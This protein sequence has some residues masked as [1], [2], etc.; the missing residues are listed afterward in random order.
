MAE[1]KT[2]LFFCSWAEV[3]SDF[4]PADRC[5]VYD[6][7]IAYVEDGT[8]PDLSPVLMMAF[9]FIKKDIDEMQGKYES[10]CERNRENIRRRWQK[11]KSA[12]REAYER[13]QSNTNEYERIQS[14][15]NEY[16]TYEC[17]H[18]KHKHEHEHEHNHE[19]EQN[20][21]DKS[22]SSADNIKKETT[23]VVKKKSAARFTPPTLED[24]AN[25]AH[26]KGYAINAERFISYYESVGWRVGRNQ[27]KDWRAA[28]RTWAA[29]DRKQQEPVK[30]T[31]G[32]GIGEWRDEKGR[33]RYERSDTIV[34]E[35]APPRPS[36][37]HWWSEVTKMWENA[38]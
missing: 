38:L 2:F 6:A 30:G 31:Q 5:A 22:I 36:A 27:M 16:E 21:I 23:K 19:H 20:S 3:L 8:L 4:T 32:L 24:V 1:R 11:I 37:G 17:I 29:R 15:T 25:Y 18:H 28:V 7:A 26:E 34:P 10:K 35:D 14:N 13:I 33:R 12:E 9:K